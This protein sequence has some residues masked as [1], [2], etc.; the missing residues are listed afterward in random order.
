MEVEQ[1]MQ[2]NQLEIVEEEKESAQVIT[3]EDLL[4]SSNQ[5]QEIEEVEM[6]PDEYYEEFKKAMELQVKKS[7]KENRKKKWKSKY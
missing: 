6:E 5:N 4:Q 2:N 3:L 1:E 7:L